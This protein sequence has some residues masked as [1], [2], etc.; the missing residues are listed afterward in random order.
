MVK[1][2]FDINTIFQKIGTHNSSQNPTSGS[3]PGFQTWNSIKPNENRSIF[4]II[5]E[6]EKQSVWDKKCLLQSIRIAL[7]T[8]NNQRLKKEI[9]PLSSALSE[10]LILKYKK[11]TQSVAM[12]Y[13]VDKYLD[14]DHPFH[15]VIEKCDWILVKGLAV[16]QMRDIHFHLKSDENV[17]FSCK[18][19]AHTANDLPGSARPTI[20]VLWDNLSMHELVI[21]ILTCILLCR[22]LMYVEISS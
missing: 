1:A 22:Y 20:H 19:Q 2:D 21:F 17:F 14:R 5:S 4:Q 6:A 16:L 15:Y 10:A 11:D 13:F 9:D 18:P 12:K 7:S 3:V 8:Y